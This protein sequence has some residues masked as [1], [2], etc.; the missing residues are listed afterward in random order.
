MVGRDV[1][2]RKR[3]EEMMTALLTEKAALLD[4]ALVGII[5]VK[6]R[7]II[8]CNRRFEEMMGYTPGSAIGHSTRIYMSL[9]R[10][11][12][13]SALKLIVL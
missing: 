10:P 13:R 7:R 3:N 8:S 2:E 5:S 12:P 11:L 9:M 6:D 4:N 1:T